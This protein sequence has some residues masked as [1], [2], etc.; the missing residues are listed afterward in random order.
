MVRKSGMHYWE[1]R[2]GYY[3][4]HKG[5]QVLLATGPKDG[6]EGPTW[7]TAMSRYKEIVFGWW[8]G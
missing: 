4:T 3:T 1:S 8:Q 7:A 5:R 2:G 6:P